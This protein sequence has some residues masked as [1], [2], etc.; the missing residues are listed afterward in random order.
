[1][2][3]EVK[4]QFLG[5]QQVQVSK[6]SNASQVNSE[7]EEIEIS[8]QKKTNV[9]FQ[10]LHN[11]E[12]L[13]PGSYLFIDENNIKVFGIITNVFYDTAEK[14]TC[15]ALGGA[16]NKSKRAG[17]GT[18]GST[19]NSYKNKTSRDETKNEEGVIEVI[20]KSKDTEE[21]KSHNESQ[22]NA[23]EVMIRNIERVV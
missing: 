21:E 12:Y 10:F 1:M 14:F 5:S 23:E 7:Q 3:K 9:I 18:A 4:H 16:K 15:A 2:Q 6:F 8:D 20:A 17:A 13:I 11:P 19:K 22:E